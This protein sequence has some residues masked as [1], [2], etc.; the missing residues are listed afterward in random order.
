MYGRD[1][2]NYGSS[3]GYEADDSDQEWDDHI[4]HEYGLQA[5][6]PTA[7]A[8]SVYTEDDYDLTECVTRTFNMYDD[9]FGERFPGENG[10]EEQTHVPDDRSVGMDTD[11]AEQRERHQA[12]EANLRQPST[13]TDPSASDMNQSDFV[14]YEDELPPE[15]GEF[16]EEEDIYQDNDDPGRPQNIDRHDGDDD[17]PNDRTD[18]DEDDIPCWNVNQ[19]DPITPEEAFL[20]DAARPLYF[21]T[22]KSPH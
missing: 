17:T 20:R 1:P 13:A 14:E 7:H 15:P 12:A 16:A 19:D 6:A 4:V 9:Y 11:V 21:R 18:S 3:K 8:H 22:P 2:R 10:A 5:V